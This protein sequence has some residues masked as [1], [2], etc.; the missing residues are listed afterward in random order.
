MSNERAVTN[1]KI[2]RDVYNL[3]KSTSFEGSLFG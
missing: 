1:T 3:I 2:A